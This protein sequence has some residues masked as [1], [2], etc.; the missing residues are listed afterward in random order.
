MNVQSILRSKGTEVITVSQN[1]TVTE[2]SAFLCDNRIGAVVVCADDGAIAGIMS[3]RDVVRGLY[4]RGAEVLE[5]PVS[6]LMTKDVHTCKPSD[7]VIDVMAIMTD[8]RIRHVPVI[9]GGKLA[10]IVSIGD[11]VKHRIQEAEQD[12]EAMRLYIATG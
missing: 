5:L 8:R 9:D 7:T 3:E 4:R 12:A 11:V 1:I 6:E 10:G 2:F